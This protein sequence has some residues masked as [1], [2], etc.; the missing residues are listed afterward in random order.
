[1]SAKSICLSYVILSLANLPV[2]AAEPIAQVISVDG[3]VLLNQGEG[4]QTL[5]KIAALNVG[6]QLLVS[7]DASVQLNYAAA[8]CTSKFADPALVTLSNAAPCAKKPGVKKTGSGG[9]AVS[10]AA[11]RTSSAVLFPSFGGG[12]TNATPAT[13]PIAVSLP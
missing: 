12:S 6:D 13:A 8:G 1:M 7:K 3:K 10:G 9:G 2:F 4:F 11:Q 5:D